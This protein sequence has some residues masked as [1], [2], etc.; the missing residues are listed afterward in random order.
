MSSIVKALSNLVG[1]VFEVF[2][3]IINAI[4][5]FMQSI[6]S[7]AGSL[8]SGFTH[9]FSGMINFL[10]CMCLFIINFFRKVLMF[11]AANIFVIGTLAAVCF[12][13]MLY[14]QRQAQPISAKKNA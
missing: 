11:V 8:L 9:A 10:F 6:F 2:T 13:Y 12:A 3:S 14:T 1:S 5:S 4:F 7:M